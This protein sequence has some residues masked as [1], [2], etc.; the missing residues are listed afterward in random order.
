MQRLLKNLLKVKIIFL[1][2]SIEPQFKNHAKKNL[3]P[4]LINALILVKECLESSLLA[5]HWT[6]G[7]CHYSGESFNT[8]IKF[9]ANEMTI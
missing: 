6:Q 2:Y 5:F 9:T 8:N 3:F 7:T 1:L 4:C